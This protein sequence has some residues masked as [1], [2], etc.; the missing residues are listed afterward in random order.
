MGSRRM[1]MILWCQPGRRTLASAAT[2]LFGA[3][4][5]RLLYLNLGTFEGSMA[6]HSW[7]GGTDS[8][9]AFLVEPLS[10]ALVAPYCI[11]G[12]TNKPPFLCGC[13]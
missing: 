1:L 11:C 9:L 3:A 8:P 4:A 13:G 2:V 12:I 6:N 10:L 7:D 5:L